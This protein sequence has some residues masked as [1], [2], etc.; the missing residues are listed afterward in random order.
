MKASVA[1]LIMSLAS[2][3]FAQDDAISGR[4]ICE[5]LESRFVP[6]DGDVSVSNIR[7]DEVFSPGVTFIINYT[8]DPATGLSFYLGEPNRTNVLIEEL[9]PMRSFKGVSAITNLAEYRQPYSDVTLGE[10]MVNYEGSNQL[11]I[12]RSCNSEDWK[13]YF[14]QTYV[15]GLVTQVASLRCR[16]FAGTFAE[17]VARLKR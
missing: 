3:T 15:S 8:H 9:F 10:Y 14:V 13:G 11:F 6:A 1:F 4:M 2:P 17:V 16:T 12:K 5:V 7:Y